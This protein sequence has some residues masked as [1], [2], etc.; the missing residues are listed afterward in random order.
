[1]TCHRN[2]ARPWGRAGGSRRRAEIVELCGA[3]QPYFLQFPSAARV[4]AGLACRNAG[5]TDDWRNATGANT[6]HFRNR[7]GCGF[8]LKTAFHHLPGM[9]Y[10]PIATVCRGCWTRASTLRIFFRSCQGP[11]KIRTQK[12]RPTPEQLDRAVDAFIRVGREL[13]VIAA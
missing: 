4:A 1:M 3:I 11:G 12:T 2:A 7:S 6:Q 9:L 8:D 10:A 13:G 5:I